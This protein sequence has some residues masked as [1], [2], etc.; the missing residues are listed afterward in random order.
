MTDIWDHEYE[1]AP[2]AQAA[3]RLSTRSEAI[4]ELIAALAVNPRAAG[5]FAEVR[6]ETSI[7]QAATTF[8]AATW[9]PTGMPAIV[10]RNVTPWELHWMRSFG[11]RA[12][13]LVPR[14]LASGETL[15]RHAVRWLALERL[16]RTLTSAWGDRR[17]DLLAA[18]AVRFQEAARSL[19]HRFLG[20][21]CAHSTAETIRYGQSEGCPGPVDQVLA[22]L[23][24]DWDWL[25]SVCELE[26]CF[27][28]L[29]PVNALC[30]D[31]PLGGDDALLIDPIPRIAP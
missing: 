26:V 22:R 1:P 13:N 17:Y 5:R 7:D 8:L 25:V 21:V 9:A 10:K 19:D 20:V 24:A 2:W 11:E 23:H 28:D 31:D 27:G 14:V 15:G 16:P 12:P 29:T 18:A 30:R 6:W 3:G 4:E